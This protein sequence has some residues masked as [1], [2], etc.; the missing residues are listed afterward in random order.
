LGTC[1]H[2]YHS[3]CPIILMMA[4]MRC[5]KCKVKHFSSAYM[6]ISVFNWPCHNIGSTTRLTHP[7]GHKHGAQTWNGFEMLTCMLLHGGINMT[8]DNM[9]NPRFRRHVN[10]CTC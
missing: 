7:I 9:T 3:Q 1:Q 4:R 2:M 10:C 6:N 8:N 5:P